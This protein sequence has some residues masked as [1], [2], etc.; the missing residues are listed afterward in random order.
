VDPNRSLVE[1]DADITCAAPG[2]ERVGDALLHV[3]AHDLRN[4][5]A[6]IKASVAAL[7]IGEPDGPGDAGDMLAII[8]DQADRIAELIST[9][10]AASRVLTDHGGPLR[11]RA[12][13]V[14]VVRQALHGLGD[15]ADQVR[16]DVP[17]RMPAVAA[18][19]ILLERVLANLIDNAITHSPPGTQVAL[20]AESAARSV[21]LWVVDQG[22]GMPVDDRGR[23]AR[24][25][26]QA[27]HGSGGLGLGLAIARQLVVA[28]GG[29][30][31]IDDTPVGGTTMAVTLPVTKP[32]RARH[33]PVVESRVRVLESR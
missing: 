28:M 8:D 25:F 24:P 31:A 26:E 4:P 17:L 13:V 27:D 23:L 10:V 16:V 11:G 9:L 21:R 18:D 1:R 6:A 30:L 3:M 19:P 20:R 15:R 2:G 7:R 22:P 5:L 12:V 29:V 14:D 33:R 32:P